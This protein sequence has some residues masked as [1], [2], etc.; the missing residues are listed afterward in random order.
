MG[1]GG[2][3]LT[4]ARVRTARDVLISSTGKAALRGFTPFPADW[5]AKVN[6][7]SVSVLVHMLS[8]MH[9]AI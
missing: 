6:F 2:G 1:G 7:M 3:M 8:C 9:V 5:H 4:A